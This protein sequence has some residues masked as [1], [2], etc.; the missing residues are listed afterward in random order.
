[1]AWDKRPVL[2]LLSRS[3]ANATARHSSL[4]YDRA[5]NPSVSLSSQ[6]FIVYRVIRF[7]PDYPPDYSTDASLWVWDPFRGMKS[8]IPQPPIPNMLKGFDA[9]FMCDGESVYVL[10]P[11]FV[12]VNVYNVWML[13]L[14]EFNIRWKKLPTLPRLGKPV[15]ASICAGEKYIWEEK[16]SLSSNITHGW[17]LS[18]S[19]ENDTW[20]HIKVKTPPP[21]NL[22]FDKSNRLPL[23]IEIISTNGK[24]MYERAPLPWH[25]LSSEFFPS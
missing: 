20:Q 19:G 5:E 16:L 4:L 6:E 3:W 15:Y 18:G 2:S 17:K 8:T 9:N 22:N 13:D 21:Q 23:Y 12:P 10:T 24:F 14:R 1:M 25:D 7:P 11:S